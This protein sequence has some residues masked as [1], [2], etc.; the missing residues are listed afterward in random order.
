MSQSQQEIE[1]NPYGWGLAG[2]PTWLQVVPPSVVR[3]IEP[4]WLSRLF[5]YSP[6][7]QQTSAVTQSISLGP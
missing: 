5:V 1:S 4:I 6:T 2:K 3:L 7:T